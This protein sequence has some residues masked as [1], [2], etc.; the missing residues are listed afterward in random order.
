M[1][2]DADL[3]R[4]LLLDLREQQ[5]SPPEGFFLQLDDIAARLSR[6]RSEIV[7]ALESLLALDFIDAPGAWREDGW[8]FR[9]LTRKGERLLDLIED[10]GDWRNVKSAYLPES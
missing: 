9:K 4:A 8:I 6:E 2:P 5:L 10:E 3:M 7:D 1:P